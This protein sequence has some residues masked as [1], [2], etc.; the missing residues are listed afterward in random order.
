VAADGVGL[1]DVAE[2]VLV[3][4]LVHAG[5]TIGAVA[6]GPKRESAYSDAD[7]ELLSTLA[8]QAA[9]AVRNARLADDLAGRVAELAASRARIVEAEEVERRRIERDLH[10]GVQQQLIALAAKVELARMHLAGGDHEAVDRMLG[11]VA[12]AVRQAHAELRDLARGIH[13]AVLSDRG[14]IEAVEARTSLLPF[15]VA[16]ET[17]AG[18]RE[19]RFAEAL[20]GAAYFV[21]AEALTNVAKHASASTATVRVA[22]AAGDLRI[23]VEDDGVGFDPQATALFGLRGLRD[24]VEALG[25]RLEIIGSPRTTIAACFPIRE[26]EL[27]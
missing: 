22:E 24:R 13:P 5:E 10:D 12:D 26:R 4:P 19:T 21:I 6:C 16:V 11:D 2:A 17:D 18:L 27:V 9:L 7:R 3:A 23:E 25:G 15:S 20:E 14:L 8:G 1:D